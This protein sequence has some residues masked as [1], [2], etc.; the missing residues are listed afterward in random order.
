MTF[1][2]LASIRAFLGNFLRENSAWKVGTLLLA[3]IIW[4]WIQSEEVIEE[5]AWVKVEYAT[6]EGLVMAQLP[7]QRVRV[8]VSG[9]RSEIKALRKKQDSLQ[10]D[11]D[12]QEFKAGVQTVD[13]VDAEIQGL[14]EK[15]EVVGLVPN[16]LQVELESRV[17]KTVPVEP[18]VVGRIADGFRVSRITLVPDTVELSGPASLIEK[19]EMVSTA[20]LQVAGLAETSVLSVDVTLPEA[21]LSRT[22]TE[23][24]EATVEV[25]SVTTTAGFDGVPVAIRA[26]GWTSETSHVH[27]TLAGPLSELQEITHD[28]VTAIIR[29]PEGTPPRQVTVGLEPRAAARVDIVHSGGSTIEAV[30][31]EPGRIVLEPEE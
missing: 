19:V 2:T 26:G 13:F 10:L 12:M 14:P 4:A 30:A 6:P 11:V 21:N 3:I 23:Q 18:A 8:T 16:S 20:G 27:V 24:I 7:T 9:T 22:S 31:I 25:E 15:L 1:P 29:I 17:L 5:S 28:E